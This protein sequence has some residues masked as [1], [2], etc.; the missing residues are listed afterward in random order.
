MIIASLKVLT[1]LLQFVFV[2]SS[3]LGIPGN[4]ISVVFPLV[5]WIAGYITGWQ[6]L[7]ISVIIIIGEVLEQLLGIITGKKSGLDNKSM[8]FSFIGA[9]IL[10]IL[11]APIFFGLGA[12]L[13]AF[14]GAFGGTFVYE[15]VTTGDFSLSIERGMASLK[16]K[17]LGTIIK[18]ALGVSS[19][20]LSAIYLF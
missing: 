12:V 11:M 2:L 20:V 5:W 9:I 8:I 15:Y 14:I 19:V 18:L 10:G 17:F 4:I 1:L 7:I 16:G 6:F 3:V 13:G